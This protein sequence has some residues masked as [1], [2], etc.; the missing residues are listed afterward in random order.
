MIV[1]A[2]KSIRLIWH[3]NIMIMITLKHITGSFIFYILNCLYSPKI[4]NLMDAISW[5]AS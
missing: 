3:Y 1:I 4:T 2:M 5:Y